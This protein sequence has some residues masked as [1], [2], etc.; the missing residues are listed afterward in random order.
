[1]YKAIILILIFFM[2]S[3][4]FAT[5]NN[6]GH[7]NKHGHKSSH[8]HNHKKNKNTNNS[9]A[10][11]VDEKDDLESIA[12]VLK[13]KLKDDNVCKNVILS[14]MDDKLVE[15]SYKFN[16]VTSSFTYYD[17]YYDI[18]KLI[19]VEDYIVCM[20]KFKALSSE[21]DRLQKNGE[22]DDYIKSLKK[23]EQE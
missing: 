2:T 7:K 8:K 20:D 12:L 11:T 19:E 22:Y 23:R 13:D 5:T 17:Y 14:K 18:R 9:K 21:M 16:N 15:Y 3:T 10:S 6:H 1:M 4:S